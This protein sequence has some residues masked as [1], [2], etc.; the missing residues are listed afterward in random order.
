MAKSADVEDIKSLSSLSLSSQFKSCCFFAFGLALWTLAFLFFLWV[1]AENLAAGTKEDDDWSQ[2]EKLLLFVTVLTGPSV[3]PTPET[4][5]LCCTFHLLFLGLYHTISLD[6]WCSPVELTWC[7]G[8][9]PFPTCSAY[10]WTSTILLLFEAILLLKV[11]P[12]QFCFLKSYFY[13]DK[14]G[15]LP[16]KQVNIILYY[17]NC[18]L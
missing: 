17:I 16:V 18:S 15:S 7:G 5:L 11:L 6:Q 13:L 9:I 14:Y 12:P 3:F 2:R 8:V 1:L 4:V 10:I